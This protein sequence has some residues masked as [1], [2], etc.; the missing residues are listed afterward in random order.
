MEKTNKVL[1]LSSIV[2]VGFVFA[3]IFYYVMGFYLLKPYPFNT[4]LLQPSIAFSDFAD[5]MPL[6]KDFAP[7]NRHSYW[8]NY[9]PLAYILLFPFSF[10]KP[11]ILSYL[12]FISGFLSSLTFMNTK[13]FYCK[14]LTKIENFQNIFILTA[15]SYPVLSVL[16]RGNFDMILFIFFAAFIF[17]FKKEKYL[18][19][20]VVL[21]VMNAI[22]PFTLIFLVLFLFKKRFKELFFNII[23]TT[24]LVIGGF[25]LLHGNFFDQVSTLILN[26]ASFQ[27]KYIYSLTYWGMGNTSSLFSCLKILFCIFPSNP[28]ISTALLAKIYTYLSLF[29]TIITILFAS[30]EKVFWKQI[31]L[32][33]LYMLLIPQIIFDYKLIFL[34]IPIYLFIN[35]KEKSRFD[36]TYIILF[37]LL[38]IPKHY[39]II[40]LLDHMNKLTL[41]AIINPLIMIIFIGLIIFEQIQSKEKKEQQVGY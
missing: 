36:L 27:Q 19:S 41:S 31:S 25:M 35:A 40:D 28:I 13:Y 16:D 33:T 7:F 17:L 4:F 24:L 34:F 5:M 10:I 39:F 21:A 23:I 37:G 22:K 8:V 26:L 18:L 1:L 30:R 20:A 38:L 3:V 6:V 14:T 9:F 15:L 29:A 32:L 12:L 2:L 11:L